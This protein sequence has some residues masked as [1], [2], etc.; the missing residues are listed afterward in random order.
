MT[1]G[2]EGRADSIVAPA[3]HGFAIVPHDG[4]DLAAET[5][6][7]YVGAGGALSVRLAAGDEIDFAGLAAGTLLPIRAIRV[8]ATGTTAAQL[9]GLY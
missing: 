6:A 4:N 3:R 7:I 8:H 9:L 2:F 1:D 5:R